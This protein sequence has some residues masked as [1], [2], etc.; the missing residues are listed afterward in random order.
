MRTASTGR[1]MERPSLPF[2]EGET[3]ANP[4]APGRGVFIRYKTG[5]GYS[6]LQGAALARE[7]H[8]VGPDPSGDS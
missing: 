7:L 1:G 8:F 2:G 6:K 5:A 3:P 4:T